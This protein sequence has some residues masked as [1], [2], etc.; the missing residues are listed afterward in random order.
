MAREIVF[1]NPSDT[2]HA[3]E[4]AYITQWGAAE[5][6][7][8]TDF[9]DQ[10]FSIGDDVQ[11]DTHHG[12]LR[13]EMP[14][15]P[16]ED[17]NMEI[18]NVELRLHSEN[19]GTP[20][21]L[22]LF[23]I[24]YPAGVLDYDN[25]SWTNYSSSGTWEGAGATG[26][27]DIDKSTNYGLGNNGKIVVG[28]LAHNT[29]TSL[30]LTG[31]VRT[32]K[33]DW[34]KTIDLV[35][36]YTANSDGG[37]DFYNLTSPTYAADVN[38]R[39]YVKITYKNNV[40]TPPVISVTPQKN[41]IDAF[42][43]VTNEVN[44]ADLTKLITCWNNGTS[45]AVTNN[46]NDV[47]DTGIKQFDST[48][49]THLDAGALATENSAFSFA[50][51]SC[52]DDVD[53]PT[54]NAGATKSNVVTI[55]R[56]DVSSAVLFTDSAC[57]SAIG[58]G[59]D[60][61]SIGEELYL[62]VVGTGGDFGGKCGAVLVNWDSGASDADDKYNR[63]EFTSSD[64][65]STNQVTIKHQFSK[66]G[67]FAVKV[68][69]EDPRGFRSDK[70]A[71]TGEA[72]DVGATAP[73]AVLKSS[74]TRVLNAKFADQD[75][76][77]LLTGS[78][79]YAIGSNRKIKR[80]EYKYDAEKSVSISTHPTVVTSYTLDNDNTVF[81]RSSSK[82]AIADFEYGTNLGNT[83]VKVYGLI[84]KAADGSN[85]VDTDDTFSH[86]EYGVASI[87]PHNDA[88]FAGKYGSSS[89]QFFKTVEIIVGTNVDVDDTT[90]RFTLA[91]TTKL[92]SGTDLDESSNIN[93]TVTN[94]TVDDGDKF[95]VGDEIQL[96]NEVMLITKIDN[97]ELYVHR[98][99]AETSAASHNDNLDIF[100]TNRKINTNLR[101]VDSDTQ[102][103]ATAKQLQFGGLTFYQAND[104][105]GCTF[106]ASSNSITVV[107]ASQ[108]A[109]T[110]ALGAVDTND[111]FKMG[112]RIGDT[113]SVGSTVNNGT[114]AVPITHVIRDI[115]DT[116]GGSVKYDVIT[117]DSIST[118]ETVAAKIFK[119]DK[120]L[121]PLSIA[122]FDGGGLGEVTN[123]QMHAF[124]DSS[125][126][127][128]D[129]STSVDILTVEPTVLDL[130]SLADFAIGNYNIT[131][132]G[133]LNPQ[134]PLGTR[135]YPVGNTRISLGI[136]QLVMDARILSQDT[137]RQ[138]YNLI[139][140]DTYDYVFFDSTKVDSD[141]AF[142][143]LKLQLISGNIV[144]NPE[145]AGQYTANLTFSI[146]GEEV[147]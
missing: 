73:V 147:Q 57:T 26:E 31:L 58:A 10:A 80:F 42:V 133:G 72:V 136:P 134:M 52:D 109:S 11:N 19:T 68:Q 4:T 59:S 37:I 46:P 55:K 92:D 22:T 85:V 44:D 89:S 111:W 119:S 32:K 1:G 15:K 91:A 95:S 117:V 65:T 45:V 43:N 75:S 128:S 23:L 144:K 113:I 66:E 18:T 131:R 28:T 27:T 3:A 5:S 7:G 110:G 93:S 61:V 30:P 90:V 60:N 88:N 142:K 118:N 146:I 69:V 125:F 84:S 9:N 34:G 77:V 36:H 17:A 56:P 35:F 40:P 6:A 107:N 39:P 123:I 82:I 98:G 86:Y 135:R 67:A 2:D 100:I 24:N 49:T 112:F 101:F 38:E 130:D 138:I 143:Q 127:G 48:N 64:T 83:V 141:S 12:F 120:F 79:S 33:L 96:N 97:N 137:Y 103:A 78:G 87:S 63:Y 129:S 74:K 8:F 21:A 106:T 121:S 54:T 41:G 25:M 13:I 124:D 116:S 71:L 16:F 51:F 114:D 29:H 122:I 14:E 139:E 50:V 76:A 140:G 105:S 132:Q 115:S 62:K 126:I 94:F 99:W 20:T 102:G 108:S 53:N 47:T 70:T 145:Y 81:D 104:A